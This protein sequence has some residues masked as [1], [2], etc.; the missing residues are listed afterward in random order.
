MAESFDPYHR[1]LGIPPDEQPADHYRLL[2]LSLFEGDPEVIRDAAERQIAHVQ[3]YGLG[4]HLALSQQ[5][6][7]ELAEAKACLLDPAR[8]A[9]YDETFRQPGVLPALLLPQTLPTPPPPPPPPE[10]P[11]AEKPED[12]LGLV[13]EP[14]PDSSDRRPFYLGL[15]IGAGLLLGATIAVVVF[16]WRPA[17][18]PNPPTSSSNAPGQTLPAESPGTHAASAAKRPS[19]SGAAALRRGPKFGP[20]APQEIE[21]GATLHLA[22]PIAD[23]GAPKSELTFALGTQPPQGAQID[24]RKGVL[25]WTPGQQHGS[26]EYHIPVI[27]IA[28]SGLR[29]EVL[30]RVHVKV[31]RAN[32]PP[33]IEPLDR[34][35]VEVGKPLEFQIT[36]SDPDG[37][38]RR[39]RYELTRGP[40][41]VAVDPET[42]KGTCQAPAEEAEKTHMITV[43]VR[44]D[45]PEG[46]ASQTSFTVAVVAP[47]NHPPEGEEDPEEAEAPFVLQFPSGEL[48]STDFEIRKQA[49]I[50]A[51]GLLKSWTQKQLNVLAILDPPMGE[52]ESIVALCNYRW[53]R[54]NGWVVVFHEGRDPMTCSRD[55]APAAVAKAKQGASIGFWEN[56]LPK[57]YVF[58][59]QDNWQGGLATWDTQGNRHYW[60]RYYRGR[61][62]QFSCLFKEDRL[63]MVLECA[64]GKVLGAHLIADNAI[65]RSFADPAA[66]RADPTAGPLL[67]EMEDCEERLQAEEKAFLKAVERAKNL[68]V[69][70]ANKRRLEEFS[71]RVR[72]NA[73]WT[74]AVL[75]GLWRQAGGMVRLRPSP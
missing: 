51:A 56:V 38:A 17:T 45:G 58:Y 12:R 29:D 55:W 71:E 9:A 25:T 37:H 67:Q 23:P 65:E 1:W 14:V 6:L 70:A 21:E 68:R 7:N 48:K 5:I 40:G 33:R 49:M 34:Q 2:G 10:P 53:A 44:E 64:R 36:A 16:S 28:G 46:L 39:F 54:L 26:G 8:K 60:S 27:A 50:D 20:V 35:F 73:D 42:G 4:R 22:L 19:E 31:R 75:Q 43:R 18:P 15:G 59:E 13:R 30:V 61:R 66:A 24:P 47:A 62:D 52:A 57:R 72:K 69:G 11:R 32:R 74:E 41:W 3:R 63:R